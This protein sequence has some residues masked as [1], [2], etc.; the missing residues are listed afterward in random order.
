MSIRD[1]LGHLAGKRLPPGDGHPA[2]HRVDLHSVAAAASPVGG[3]DGRPGSKEG[4][5]HDIVGLAAVLDGPLAKR[6][7][8]RS[9]MLGR[10][11]RTVFFPDRVLR[12]RPVPGCFALPAVEDVLMA[13]VVMGPA[14]D[15]LLLHPY[16]PLMV[17]NAGCLN[18]R[19]KG[20]DERPRRA[21]NIG[22]ALQ[23]PV[24]E[25]FGPEVFLAGA[26][27]IIGDRPLALAGPE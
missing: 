9:W 5:D 27:V 21:K 3:D 18:G 22:I 13:V 11:H 23:R 25:G 24:P 20:R 26:E 14:H 16:E 19:T 10:D 4:V 15:E 2:V 6:D 17:L 8:L 12:A 1:F 7:R